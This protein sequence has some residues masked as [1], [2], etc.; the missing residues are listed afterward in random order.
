MTIYLPQKVATFRQAFDETC[1]RI[2][3]N[4]KDAAFYT[5]LVGLAGSLQE[6][7]LTKD[8]I[9]GFENESAKLKQDF[10]V[11]SLAALEDSWI[12]LWKYHR[13][14]F[15]H[16]KQLVQIK[17]IVTKPKEITYST[18]YRQISFRMWEFRH[19]SPFCDAIHEIPKLF[20]DAQFNI[21]LGTNQFDYSNSSKALYFAKKMVVPLQ[22]KKK[23]KLWNFHK[24]IFT[25]Q[26]T[27]TAFDRPVECLPQALFSPKIEEIEKQFFAPGQNDHEKRQNIIFAAEINPISCWERIQFL[28]QCFAA[29]EPPVSIP[30]KGR[31]QTIRD[32]SWQS[33][34]KRCEA[35]VLLGAKMALM[36]KLSPNP[37]SDVDVFLACEHQIH[38]KD[39]EQYIQSLKS[40]IHHCL[41]KIED[42][43]ANERNTQ[44]KLP[45]SQKEW[46]L[47]DLAK[48]YWDENSKAHHDEVFE[49]YLVK[50]PPDKQLS[51]DRWNKIIQKNH[52]D[53]RSPKDKKRGKGKKTSQN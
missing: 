43:Q 7:H 51:R 27:S 44:G 37:C 9:Q 49:N 33:A 17:R 25:H 16:R 4:K 15:K 53:P 38:R 26:F 13:R 46:F 28:K 22:L 39:Y 11:A 19:F 31:W 23:D 20:K 35:G 18:L 5:L 42:Q 6:H 29:N 2:T 45:G 50:C 36:Q 30:F 32:S 40:H 21:K 47:I 8:F 34:Q 14:S 10:S 3:N 48:Q 1:E 41:L 24:K 12:R 52:L